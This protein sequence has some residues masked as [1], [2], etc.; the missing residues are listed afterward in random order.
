MRR[1]TLAL[2][3]ATALAVAAPAFAQTPPAQPAPEADEAEAQAD[4]NAP[5]PAEPAAG[6]AVDTSGN[7]EIVVTGSILRRTTTETPS[8]VTVLSM[9]GM[10]MLLKPSRPPRKK[11]WNVMF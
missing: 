6:T 7:E 2:A 9:V 8:P 1:L 4:P 3:A 10:L 11:N 5:A